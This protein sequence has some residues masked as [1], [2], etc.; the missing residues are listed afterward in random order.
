MSPIPRIW[1]LMT[2]LA[3]IVSCSADP[4][5]TTTASPATT[6][7]PIAETTMTSTTVPPVSTTGTDRASRFVV[8]GD[9][10]G[11]SEAEYEVAAAIESLAS[12]EP[13]DGL[14]TTGDNFYTDD[15][16]RIWTIP[17]GWLGKTGIPIYA[18]WGN[19]DL[20][21]ARRQALVQ[22]H[23]R[24]P[25]RWYARQLHPGTLLVLD[26]NDLGNAE[27]TTWLSQALQDAASPVIVVSHHPAFS[28]G[29]HG[30]TAAIVE[31]WVPLIEDHDV[32][33]VLSGHDHD[34][35]RFEEDGVTYV[36]TGG[37][38]QAIRPSGSC[39]SSTPARI[40]SDNEHHHFL[41]LEV[42]PEEVRVTAL[43]PEGSILDSFAI[44]TPR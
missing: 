5:G 17:Y 35:Q 25:G 27:Q 39:S 1:A 37:G 7:M 41:V 8:I 34:Y 11:G 2:L 26:S 10:G 19:H 15:I 33:L 3:V 18:A 20:V 22:Q 9:F 14:I 32:P 29:L 36:V 16:E 6:S 38:G 12:E 31:Q 28:C 13:I 30:N 44:P 43:T 40:E 24:P 4:P 21:S 23:L 42:S